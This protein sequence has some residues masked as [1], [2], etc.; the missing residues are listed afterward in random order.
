MTKFLQKWL[1]YTAIAIGLIAGLTI[2][3]ITIAV[4]MVYLFGDKDIAGIATTVVLIVG[5]MGFLAWQDKD[6]S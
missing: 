1:K 6:F 5:A 4:G 3:Y 2:V